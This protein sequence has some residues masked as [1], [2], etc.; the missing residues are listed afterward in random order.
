MHSLLGLAGFLGLI[1]LAFGKPAAA[2]VA[3]V[4]ICLGVLA[5]VLIVFDI[6]TGG[7]LSHLLP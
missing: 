7:L 2:F 3:Q 4:I 1:G 5:I 6:T